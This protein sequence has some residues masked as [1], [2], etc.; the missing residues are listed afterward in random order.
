MFNEVDRWHQ[1][2]C[3]MGKPL[4]RGILP[5]K[6]LNWHALKCHFKHSLGDIL[7]QKTVLEKVKLPRIL[8]DYRDCLFNFL[9]TCSARVT[10]NIYHTLT[11]CPISIYRLDLAVL[12]QGQSRFSYVP[13]QVFSPYMYVNYHFTGITRISQKVHVDN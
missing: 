9:Y 11:P 7:P 6:N 2:K 12:R 10:E 5:Q 8:R 1:L 4:G 13:K 3:Q